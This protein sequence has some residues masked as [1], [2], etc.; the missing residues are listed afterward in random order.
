MLTSHLLEFYGTEC[1]HCKEME[2]L[3]E[4][5]AKEEGVEVERLEVWHNTDNEK[6]LRELAEGKCQGIPFFFNTKTEE[7]ICGNCDYE[8]L[9]KWALGN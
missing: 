4:R 1:V 8:R 2:P 6:R 7:W 3:M 5:L 9:K